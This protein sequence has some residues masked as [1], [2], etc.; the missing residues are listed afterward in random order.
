MAVGSYEA[1][2]YRPEFKLQ[3]GA[4]LRGFWSDDPVEN[5]SYFEWKYEDNPHAETPLGIVAL[6]KGEVVGYRGYFACRFAVRGKNDNIGILVPGDT[7]VSPDH[8]RKGLSVVMGDLAKREYA[9]RHPLFLNMTCSRKS[10]PGY[11]RMGFQPLA[12]K[13]H[14]TRT[15]LVASV[16]SLLFD[17]TGA[18]IHRRIVENG[19]FGQIEVSSHPRPADMAAVAASQDGGNGT[20]HLFQDERFFR[21]RYRNP[22]RQYLFYYAMDGERPIGYVVVGV[23][24]NSGRAFILDVAQENDTAVQMILEHLID[25]EHFDVL[26]VYDFCVARP[27]ADTLRHLGFSDRG[28]LRTVERRLYGE[29][30]VLFRPVKETYADEDLLIEGLDVRNIDNW[31]LKPICSDS[32]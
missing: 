16:R 13:V 9:E 26:S 24:P 28:L 11:R 3:V 21:W 19:R 2:P 5:L 18:P 30:P 15:S 10:L 32:A 23:T 6:H 25:A 1:Q 17:R 14:L 4:L 20:L 22:Q 8:R 31:S 12:T 27:L 7:Y 29:L